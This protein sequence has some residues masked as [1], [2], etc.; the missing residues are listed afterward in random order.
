M[1]KVQRCNPVLRTAAETSR[2]MEREEQV[3]ARMRRGVQLDTSKID[4]SLVPKKPSTRSQADLVIDSRYEEIERMFLDPDKEP[5]TDY[6]DTKTEAAIRER[7]RRAEVQD[8]KRLTQ[9]YLDKEYNDAAER[10]RFHHKKLLEL[11][12]ERGLKTEETYEL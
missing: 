11:I 10:A 9:A 4:Y 8:T 5:T 6:T 1:E 2:L 12:E 7:A 3:L